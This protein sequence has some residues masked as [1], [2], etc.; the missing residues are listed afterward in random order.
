MPRESRKGYRNHDRAKRSMHEVMMIARVQM[1]GFIA[2][3]GREVYDQP[4]P[5]QVRQD[6]RE[7]HEAAVADVVSR[8][9]RNYPTGEQMRERRHDRS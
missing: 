6:S 3:T 4:H 9:R 1:S 8:L 5:I 2:G 7:G